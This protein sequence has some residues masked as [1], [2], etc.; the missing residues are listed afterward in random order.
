MRSVIKILNEKPDCDFRSPASLTLVHWLSDP[1]VRRL[2]LIKTCFGG[3]TRWVGEEL[4]RRR[5]NNRPYGRN[6]GKARI[7]V[8]DESQNASLATRVA[9]DVAAA[10]GVV[11]L[12]MGD[13]NQVGSEPPYPLLCFPDRPRQS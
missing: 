3:M 12:L 9:I 4:A 5:A 11:T 2:G 8:F 6:L 7:V 10:S 1:S 13:P